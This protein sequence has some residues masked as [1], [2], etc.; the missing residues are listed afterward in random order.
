[1]RTFRKFA[2]TWYATPK[3]MFVY[4]STRNIP[5]RET[6]LTT[7]AVNACFVVITVRS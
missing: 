3:L 6:E 5:K 4:L 2:L 7:G 1:M